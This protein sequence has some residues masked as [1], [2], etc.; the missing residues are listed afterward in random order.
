MPYASAP[1]RTTA[2]ITCSSS[3]PSI[4]NPNLQLPNPKK[5]S[6]LP[7]G[8]CAQG[9]RVPRRDR[10]GSPAA[11]ARTRRARQS[12]AGSRPLRRV[13]AGRSAARRR[14]AMTSTRVDA[15][16]GRNAE[17]AARGDERQPRVRPP[18][19]RPA[20]GACRSRCRCRSRAIAARR[21]AISR[22]RR[23]RRPSTS[24]SPARI[25]SSVTTLPSRPDRLVEDRRMRRRLL[26]G[27]LRAAPRERQTRGVEHGG[28]VLRPGHAE[29]ETPCRWRRRAAGRRACS[30]PEPALS[31][32][33]ASAALPTT[34]TIR[35]PPSPNP[36]SST[37]PIGSSPGKYFAASA[38]LMTTTGSLVSRSEMS[39]VRPRRSGI[40]IVSK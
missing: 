7:I 38:S 29:D 32:R 13:P 23:R 6:Q 11:P 5:N 8:R 31:V 20:T 10:S 17:D 15:D 2:S 16:R 37:R 22:R 26:H 12:P 21:S 4:G 39:N 30:A 14:A 9:C 35:S 25:D 3:D 27:E 19:R 1:V 34:P 40:P 36:E 28:N 18:A 33:L 24:A